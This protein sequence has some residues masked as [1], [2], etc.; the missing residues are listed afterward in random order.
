MKYLFS[1]LRATRKDKLHQSA[2]KTPRSPNRRLLAV[3]AGG[4]MLQLLKWNRESHSQS[5]RYEIGEIVT[6]L[7]TT[8]HHILRTTA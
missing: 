5:G 3:K 4:Q 8:P 2:T 1:Q 7:G 6:N